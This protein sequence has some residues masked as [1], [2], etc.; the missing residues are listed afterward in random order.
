MKSCAY[1]KLP[2]DYELFKRID[3]TE[4]RNTLKVLCLWTVIAVLVMVLSMLHAHPIGEAFN[5]PKI[6][7]AFCMTAMVM[8]LMVY[9]FL[10]EGVH[11]MFIRMFTGTRASFGF[12]IRN[13]MAYAHSTWF[14]SKW[15][16]VIIAAAPV[17]IWG[18]V[19][20]ILLSGIEEQYFWYLYG[21]QIFNVTGAAG[22][23]YVICRVVGM[24]KEV[25]AF[26]SGKAMN[27]YLPAKLQ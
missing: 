21:I 5:M 26:D 16:Y 11:G 4:E 7:V 23:I 1:E 10:H 19:I 24:P 27:F 2:A 12:D 25:L 8:G 15:S 20:G 13:G 17:V 18:T 3:L 6:R 14:F 22:D 9:I